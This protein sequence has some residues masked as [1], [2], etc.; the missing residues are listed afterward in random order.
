MSGTFFHLKRQQINQ[1]MLSAQE[2]FERFSQ[3]NALVVGDVMLDR[4]LSGEVR[5]IS[6]E[7]P[8][9]VVQLAHSE[10]RLGGAANVALNLRALGATPY[11]CSA[12]G[13]DT[14]GGIFTELLPAHDLPSEGILPL[15]SRITTVKTRVMAGAQH[16]LRIDREMVQPLSGEE[17]SAF[18][19]RFRHILESRAIHVVL[20]QDYNKGVLSASLIAAVLAEAQ[21]R[22][23]PS[24]VDPKDQHFWAY[25]GATLF[26]PNLKEIRAQLPQPIEPELKSLQSAAAQIHKKLG[27][28]LSMIT[29]S[30]H[31]V[32]ISDDQQSLLLPT[33]VKQ[34]ADVS[35][36][37]D[38]VISVVSLAMALGV[39][40][41]TLAVLAN[42]AGGQVCE[43]VGVVPVDKQ[44]LL[45]DFLLFQ[46]SYL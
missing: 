12:I 1:D 29:L 19:D 2:L 24:A 41:R 4:Y 18:L 11:L 14:D 25:R 43:K 13:Q 31:G 30:E 16:L 28:S 10:D 44:R 37:G 32:F 38:T 42:L 21:K 23:I 5:R 35:G 45:Q 7:A 39:D 46:R 26:K 17:E 9:P 36:A 34:V 8:V 33:Q 40:L 27:N 3:L 20:L 6:P 22:G 15:A